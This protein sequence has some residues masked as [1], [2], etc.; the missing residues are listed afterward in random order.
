ME[1]QCI[2]IAKAGIVCTFPARTSIIAAANPIGGHYNK[3]KTVSENLK[4]SAALLSRFDLVFI[5]LDKVDEDMDRLLSAHV[6][7]LHSSHSTGARPAHPAGIRAATAEP[8]SLETQLQLLPGEA[9]EPVPHAITRKCE[10]AGNPILFIYSFL[11][12]VST[13]RYVSYARKYV[14]PK[15]RPEAAVVLQQVCKRFFFAQHHSLIRKPR[16]Q[17][18]LE[19]RS[20]HRG[21]DCTPIT[22]RQIESLIRLAEA[23]ARLELREF[24]TVQD[25]TEVVELMKRSFFD[26]LSDE[27]GTLDFTV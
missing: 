24:V 14:H 4:M 8:D 23:R 25:A 6:M 3:A 20:K 27:F 5:L 26:T 1:Q 19:L 13:A 7:T 10:A 18:Y 9:F 21:A 11:L 15:L 12:G 17:F 16:R 2:S 22:T